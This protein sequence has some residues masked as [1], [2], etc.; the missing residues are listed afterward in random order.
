MQTELNFVTPGADGTVRFVL[1]FGWTGTN[2]RAHPVELVDMRPAASQLSLANEGFV[3]DRIVSGVTDYADADE[4][5]RLWMP[6]VEAMILRVTGG[7][8]AYLFAGPNIRFSERDS[9]SQS[10]SIS[11][12]ARA[13]HG[14][15]PATF[16]FAQFPRQP[17]SEAAW[18]RLVRDTG[19]QEPRCWKVFNIWQMLSP[20]PQDVS[21]ALCAL[22]SLAL[23]DYVHGEGFFCRSG[24]ERR[25][26]AG[27][28]RYAAGVR[29]HLS[30]PQSG[31]EMELVFR[32]V[33]RRGAGISGV[34]S[35]GWAVL[36]SRTA[37][38]G[39]IARRR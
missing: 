16:H 29:H 5:A 21:L 37:W 31:T 39:D 1:D 23:E 36:R 20:P 17:V 2:Q 4:V 8:R 18:A 11:A 33:A 32:H 30:P 26:G 7:A 14:D 27:A 22:P 6:A 15:L 24:S 9:K 28:C 12:P 13:V 10:T 35:A 19:G 3:I 38:R 34:R 25:R